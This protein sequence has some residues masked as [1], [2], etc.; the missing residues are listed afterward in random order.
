MSEQERTSTPLPWGWKELCQEFNRRYPKR[1]C[2]LDGDF[3]GRNM[4]TPVTLE[5]LGGEQVTDR[6]T[7]C[8]AS[9]SASMGEYIPVHEI[10]RDKTGRICPVAEHQMPKAMLGRGGRCYIGGIHWEVTRHDD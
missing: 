4:M 5:F 9:Y 2:P 1:A 3:R 10:G 8:F 6:S 7:R